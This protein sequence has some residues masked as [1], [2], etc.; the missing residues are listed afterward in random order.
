MEWSNL[1]ICSSEVISTIAPDP[2]SPSVIILNPVVDVTF[3]PDDLPGTYTIRMTMTDHG[4]S[5]YAKTEEQ[6]QLMPEK[7]AETKRPATTA[8]TGLP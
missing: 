7:S 6:F 3:G 4:H 2:R 1:I 5:A 8:T